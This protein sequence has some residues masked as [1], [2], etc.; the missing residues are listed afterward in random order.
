MED[1]N[2]KNLAAALQGHN[3]TNED[4]NITE[5]ETSVEESA[6]LDQKTSEDEPA[7]VEKS[8][9]TEAEE[10]KASDDETE[11]EESEDESELAEDESGKRYVPESRFKQVYGQ[12]KQYER[13]LQSQTSEAPKSSGDTPQRT[14]VATLKADK[15]DLL[16]LELLRQTLPQ[17]DPDS[18]SYSKTLDE[19]G[20]EIY[21]SNPGITRL[22]AARRAVARAKQLSKAE[23]REISEARAVKSRQSDQGITNRVVSRKAATP[24]PDE[25][26]LEQK[27][28]WLKENGLW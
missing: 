23:A 19:M 7:T 13:E 27:E 21:N 24:N 18:K 25:M 10:P 20:Y 17:F 6:T 5:E 15:S 14:S 2:L 22:E 4:G 16:E 12:M 3:V 9:E 26:T 28:A 11:N 8:A 1:A